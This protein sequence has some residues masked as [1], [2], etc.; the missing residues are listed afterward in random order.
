ME[1]AD[2]Y[3]SAREE[4]GIR[5]PPHH[6][7]RSSEQRTAPLH[8][9]KVRKFDEGFFD[10]EKLGRYSGGQPCRIEILLPLAHGQLV[11]DHDVTL[12]AESH[13]P[14]DDYLPMEQALVN[15]K[16]IKRHRLVAE[17]KRS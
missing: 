15:P 14:A 9:Q 13:P 1:S 3:P 10:R 12:E 17:A 8:V 4:S 6:T 16:Q 2:V 5:D 11:I 7:G